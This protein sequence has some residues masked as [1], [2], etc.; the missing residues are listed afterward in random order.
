MTTTFI[1]LEMYAEKL[2]INIQ[3]PYQIVKIK[4][5]NDL[6]DT[7]NYT[8]FTTAKQIIGLFYE[9]VSVTW[10]RII[11]KCISVVSQ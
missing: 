5:E 10:T 4:A 1:P 2:D 9:H 7:N 8:P 6:E 3:K 11:L